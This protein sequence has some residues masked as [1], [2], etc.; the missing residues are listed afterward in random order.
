M[1]KSISQKQEP[2]N[3]WRLYILNDFQNDRKKKADIS[4]FILRKKGSQGWDGIRNNGREYNPIYRK[5]Y[6]L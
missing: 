4:R 2:K 6:I 5:N 1:F 3:L